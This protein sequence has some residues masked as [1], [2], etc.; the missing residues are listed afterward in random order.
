MASRCGSSSLLSIVAIAGLGL[1]GIGGYN[2]LVRGCPLS[3]CDHAAKKSASTT[4]VSTT[5][6]VAKA[7]CPHSAGCSEMAPAGHAVETVAAGCS[8]SSEKS[9]P[10][11]K[12]A[13]CKDGPKD[14]A[15]DP[16]CKEGGSGCESKD[17]QVA[18][19]PGN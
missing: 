17:E 3:M 10:M 8:E 19:K 11:A 15:A 18:Q 1:A 2:A 5:S 16:C 7:E 14:C 4:L 9:C 12:V 6:S 13:E